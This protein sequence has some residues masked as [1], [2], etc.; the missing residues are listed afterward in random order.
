MSHC[1]RQGVKLGALFVVMPSGGRGSGRPRYGS[2]ATAA[3][4]RR[5]DCDADWVS[6]AA[7]VSSCVPD[8]IV[9]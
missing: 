3:V 7:N 8:P 5:K 4:L 1:A 6:L 2:G 9:P